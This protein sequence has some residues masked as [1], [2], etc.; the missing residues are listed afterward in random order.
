MK[1]LTILL[2]IVLLNSYTGWGQTCE[3]KTDPFSNE[4]VMSF[5][6][7][8]GSLRTLFYEARGGKNTLEFRVGETAAIEMTIPKGSEVLIKFENGEIIKMTTKLDA[9]SAVS[10]TNIGTS[11]V[12]FSTYFLKM[13]VGADQLKKLANNK[14]SDM[15][16]PDLHGGVQTYDSKEL[17][18][19]FERFLLEGAKCLSEAK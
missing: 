1:N 3:K 4:M 2:S 19:R 9:R 17:R 15:Q 5:E 11:I 13:E 18:N 12:T 10:N 6:W 7:K 16:F 14:V 8:S